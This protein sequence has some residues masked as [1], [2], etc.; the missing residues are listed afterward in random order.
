MGAAAEEVAVTKVVGADVL[1]GATALEA[2]TLDETIAELEGTIAELVAALV[3][4]GDAIAALDEPADAVALALAVAVASVPLPDEPEPQVATAP[5][6]G[7]YVLML[8]P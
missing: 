2:M 1:M 5:P 8:K 7:V 6:G 4:I 3:T